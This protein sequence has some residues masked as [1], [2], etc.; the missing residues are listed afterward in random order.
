MS[1]NDYFS[2]RRIRCFARHN[3]VACTDF[4]RPPRITFAHQPTPDMSCGGREHA[5]GA[6]AKLVTKLQIFFLNAQVVDFEK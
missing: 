1:A 2:S 6:T 5:L 3:A 4:F